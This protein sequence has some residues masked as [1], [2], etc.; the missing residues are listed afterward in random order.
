MIKEKQFWFYLITET[1]KSRLTT[2]GF[3]L[4]KIQLQD[5]SSLLYLGLRIYSYL[6]I[7]DQNLRYVHEYLVVSSEEITLW[8]NKKVLFKN[9]EEIRPIIPRIRKFSLNVQEIDLGAISPNFPGRKRLFF[10]NNYPS[11]IMNGTWF[12]WIDGINK[13]LEDN[14]SESL[15]REIIY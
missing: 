9:F 12:P 10:E 4:T 1:S 5:K 13:A 6:N 11:V 8:N 15:I 7:F 14:Y 3:N 2:I